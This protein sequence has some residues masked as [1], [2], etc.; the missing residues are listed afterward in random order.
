ML[1]LNFSFG[2]CY[3]QKSDNNSLKHESIS[4]EYKEET[5][6]KSINNL[7]GW[8]AYWNLDVNDE[9]KYL[10]SQLSEL[11][12]FEAYFDVNGNIYIPEELLDYY[13]KFKSDNYTNYISIVNDK[14]NSDG[15]ITQKDTEILKEKLKDKVLRGN[16]IDEIINLA[17]TNNFDGIEIDYEQIKKD[18]PLWQDYIIF[19]DELY[20]KANE[21]NLK[22]RII[23]EPSIPIEELEFIEGPVYVIMCYNLHTAS[24]DPGEKANINFINDLMNK[25]EKIPGEKNYAIATGGFDWEIGGKGKAISEKDAKELLKEYDAERRRDQNS[26]CVVFNYIDEN[27][28]KH[29]VWYADNVTLNAW[30]EAIH[31]KGYDISIWKLGGNLFG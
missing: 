2:G 17:L 11:S 16:H 15:K 9:I 24:S 1:I 31:K 12:Y 28:I 18:I 8:I 25:M 10:G 30:M 27:N 19:I 23:L 5:F 6:N 20:N 3:K 4:M 21:N 29:E 26:K 13:N 14:I 22:L 7:N